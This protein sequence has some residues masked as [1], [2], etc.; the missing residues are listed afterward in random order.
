MCAMSRADDLLDLVLEYNP[1][2]RGRVG[3]AR[4]ATL[5]E[6]YTGLPL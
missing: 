2:H 6:N 3:R 5:A 4:P 1:F